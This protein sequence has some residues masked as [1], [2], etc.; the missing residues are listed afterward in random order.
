M[1]LI[2]QLMF[3]SSYGNIQ[4]YQHGNNYCPSWHCCSLHFICK[5]W[6]DNTCHT[7]EPQFLKGFIEVNWYTLK[8]K[9]PFN[10]SFH[11]SFSVGSVSFLILTIEIVI[12]N[13]VFTIF[14]IP[15]NSVSTSLVQMINMMAVSMYWVIEQ[16]DLR[17]RAE[18]AMRNTFCD[19]RPFVVTA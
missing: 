17:H 12:T 10:I 18:K 1:F 14:S 16:E 8:R 6:E 3:S 15:V 7:N 9:S 2:D 5:E 4:F 13:I 11:F 19:Q